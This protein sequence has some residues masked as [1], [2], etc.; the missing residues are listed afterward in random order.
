F[1]G[2]RFGMIYGFFESFMYALSIVGVW[3]VGMIY[4]KQATYWPHIFLILLLSILLSV[5][6][7]WFVTSRK[8][9]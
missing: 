1:K 6:F 2:E 4:D 5:V 9:V 3:L 7:M 8:E